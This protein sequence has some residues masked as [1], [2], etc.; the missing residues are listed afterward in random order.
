MDFL[1]RLYLLIHTVF[2]RFQLHAYHIINIFSKIY[3]YQSRGYDL[4]VDILYFHQYH[5]SKGH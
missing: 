5:T 1:C 3:K 4:K 2:V